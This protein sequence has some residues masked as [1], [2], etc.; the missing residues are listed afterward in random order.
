MQGLGIPPDW[1]QALNTIT[2]N[3]YE[4]ILVKVIQINIVLVS[5]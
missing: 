4:V 5:L 1:A 3:F 2:Q